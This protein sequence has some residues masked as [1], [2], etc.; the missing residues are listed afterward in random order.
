[1]KSTTSILVTF[2]TATLVV[3]FFLT[4]VSFVFARN[5]DERANQQR[6]GERSFLDRAR[7]TLLEKRQGSKREDSKREASEVRQREGADERRAKLLDR[8]QDKIK[9][10]LNN[11][12]AKMNAAAERLDTLADRIFSRIEKFEEKGFDMTEAKQLLKEARESITKARNNIDS[13]IADAREAF[14]SDTPRNSFGEVVSTLT[15]TKEHLR[16]AH[17]TLVSVIRAIKAGANIKSDST[18]EK[19]DE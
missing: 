5:H 11:V 3:L 7:D 14:S 13:A 17:K 1:M 8:V 18:P 15:R 6:G 19:N 4:S 10:F 12:V 2:I 16:A 9:R